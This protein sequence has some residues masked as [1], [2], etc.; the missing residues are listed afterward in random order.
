[1]AVGE[2]NGRDC[3]VAFQ[4][5]TSTPERWALTTCVPRKSAEAMARPGQLACE[6][7]PLAEIDR[8][9]AVE[10]AAVKL[11][12]LSHCFI[13]KTAG[14]TLR[15]DDGTVVYRHEHGDDGG[16]L[17]EVNHRDW[18]DLLGLLGVEP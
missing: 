4:T 6:L 10:E 2:M 3:V 12:S 14:G 7:V 18:L 8:L 15:S 17:I 5:D 9:R 16:F 13:N 11:L 1:M